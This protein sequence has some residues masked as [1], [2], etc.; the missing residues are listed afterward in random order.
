MPRVRFHP[1][2]NELLIGLSLKIVAR[3]LGRDC[4]AISARSS[5]GSGSLVTPAAGRGVWN[6][7]E[8]RTVDRGA[9]WIP[10]S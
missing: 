6:E 2:R 3:Y 9:L 10:L 8:V 7:T 1:N 4:E 5:C